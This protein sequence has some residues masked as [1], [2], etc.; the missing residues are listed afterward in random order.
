MSVNDPKHLNEKYNELF[1][2][3]DLHGLASMYEADAILCPAPGQIVKGRAEISKRL[4]TLLTLNGSL[5]TFEQS[6][7]VFENLALLHARWS[8]AGETSD[9]RPVEMGGISSKLARLGVDG[10][11][12]YVLDMPVGGIETK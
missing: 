2:A 6:C 10:A 5:T 11:W 1:R 3:G 12:R 8:F 9:G 7:V 4:S